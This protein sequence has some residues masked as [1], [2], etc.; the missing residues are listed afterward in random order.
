NLLDILKAEDVEVYLLEVIKE[1]D[2]ARE[3]YLKQG[4]QI[5]RGFSCH[6]AQ[7]E[8]LRTGG[9]C[10]APIEEVSVNDLDW[11]ALRSMWDFPPS[12]QNSIDSVMAVPDTFTVVTAHVSEDLAG[13]GIIETGSGDIPQIAVAPDHRG[14]GIGRCMMA[15]LAALTTSDRF[16]MINVEEGSGPTGEF[17]E[18][19][20][21]GHYT[22]QYEMKLDL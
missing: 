16:A 6:L 5:S 1:N 22:A 15:R 7:R 20:G 14:K 18:A 9:E 11:D 12:W 19:V 8:A 2:P 10:P 17:A 4:F 21:M 3:L 13:Y